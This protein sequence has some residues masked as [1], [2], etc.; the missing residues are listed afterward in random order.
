MKA[1]D[2]DREQFHIVLVQLGYEAFHAVRFTDQL[3]T[4]FDVVHQI[5]DCAD[6]GLDGFQGIR[7][8]RRNVLLG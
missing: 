3:F 1:V 6:D 4:L 5:V 7:A 2:H 8:G